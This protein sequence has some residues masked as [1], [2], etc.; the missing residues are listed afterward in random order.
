MSYPPAQ[1]LQYGV[2]LAQ[3]S[4]AAASTEIL[5]SEIVALKAQ[6]G[7]SVSK[8]DRTIT[9]WENGIG[10]TWGSAALMANTADRQRIKAIRVKLINASPTSG[11]LDDL[12]TVNLPIP[13]GELGRSVAA[14]LNVGH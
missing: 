6:Y 4:G 14:L 2:T 5:A 7:V 11:S 8:S 9:S 13:M 12:A 3:E 10:A 1:T